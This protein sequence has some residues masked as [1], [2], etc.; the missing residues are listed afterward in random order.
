MLTL[1][2]VP[3]VSPS[4]LATLKKSRFF[5]EASKLGVTGAINKG[6]KLVDNFSYL[7]NFAK[8]NYKGVSNMINSI[9]SWLSTAINGNLSLA[10]IASFVWGLLS[11]LLSPCHL[12]SIPLIVGFID[13]QGKISTKRAFVISSLFS[14]GILIMIAFIGL[15]TALMGRMIGDV[16][17]LGNYLVAVIFFVVGLH[18]LEIINI[19]FAGLSKQPKV[20]HK[21]YLSAFILGLIFGLALGPC[22]FAFMAPVITVS[23]RLAVDNFLLAALLIFL[24]G[25]GH[26][27]VIIFAGTFTEV[28]QRYLNWSNDSKKVVFIKKICG[29]LIILAGLYMIAKA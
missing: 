13:G 16:S 5:K 15:I 23:F 7:A 18:M 21:G 22:T 12:A 27:S 9:F 11:I 10:L 14:L 29:I 28:I 8:R 24:Y 17:S 1:Y 2:Q 20:Q 26:C 25:L 4:L 19:P 3:K 6:K